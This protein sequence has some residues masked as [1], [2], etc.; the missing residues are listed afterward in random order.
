[1]GQ[2]KIE[3]VGVGGHGCD[4]KAKEGD[5]LYAR[6]GRFGCPDCMA[7]DFVQQLK[8]KG[9]LPETQNAAGG[10]TRALFVHWPGSGPTEVTDDMLENA[11]VKGQF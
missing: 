7:Y 8:Q 5:K 10:P 11:R 9:M 1:M 4:R 6:C 2:F 3:I